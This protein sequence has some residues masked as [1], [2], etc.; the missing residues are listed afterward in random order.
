[1]FT[2]AGLVSLVGGTILFKI[3]APKGGLW[4][5]NGLQNLAGGLALIP[6]AFLSRDAPRGAGA[7]NG[8]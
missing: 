1:M 2:A 7:R 8:G 6:F 3:L 4:I 5:G